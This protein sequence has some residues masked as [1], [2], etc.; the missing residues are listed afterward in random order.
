MLSLERY[1]RLRLSESTIVPTHGMHSDSV[2]T[3]LSKV[4][5]TSR[6]ALSSNIIYANFFVS[7][8]TFSL[9]M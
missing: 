4:V 6:Q 5:F 7:K 2:P 9:R 1:R 3:L 8:H